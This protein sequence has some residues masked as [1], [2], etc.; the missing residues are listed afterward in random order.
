MKK[1]QIRPPF[2]LEQHLLH[3]HRVEQIPLIEGVHYFYSE[4]SVTQAVTKVFMTK[5]RNAVSFKK[6]R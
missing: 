2:E 3:I 6:T 4:A 5:R 1:D